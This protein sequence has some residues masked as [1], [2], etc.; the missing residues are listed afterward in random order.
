MTAIYDFSQ[1]TFPPRLIPHVQLL[2]PLGG[3]I[4]GR[5]LLLFA[6]IMLPSAT[7][8][9]AIITIIRTIVTDIHS[10]EY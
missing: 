2:L 7:V 9:A 5:Q 10:Q 4:Q 3:Y 1:S 8:I 6:L